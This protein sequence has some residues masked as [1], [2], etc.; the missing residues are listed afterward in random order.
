MLTDES[1]HILGEELLADPIGSSNNA[2]ILLRTLKDLSNGEVLLLF[3]SFSGALVK[4]LIC[5]DSDPEP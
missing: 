4:R 5:K 2:I 3:I 1:I